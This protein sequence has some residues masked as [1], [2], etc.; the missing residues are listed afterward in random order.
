MRY[1]HQNREAIEHFS[2]GART[3]SAKHLNAI[4]DCVNE[5]SRPNP[6]IPQWEPTYE[7]E[8]GNT[9]PFKISL[10]IGDDA[11][12]VSVASGL[13]IG[14]GIS[15][16]GCAFGYH[17][18]N[19]EANTIS[20]PLYGYRDTFFFEA[21]TISL[22]YGKT[23]EKNIYIFVEAPTYYGRV[24][25]Y[26]SPG[27][28]TETEEG[29]DPP[30]VSKGYVHAE[31][32][33]EDD[34]EYIDWQAGAFPA[35][36]CIGWVNLKKGETVQLI[37]DNILF[38]VVPGACSPLVFHQV[39]GR[40]NSFRCKGGLLKMNLH[41]VDGFERLYPG[42]ELTFVNGTLSRWTETSIPAEPKEGRRF[43]SYITPIPPYELTV[44][45]NPIASEDSGINAGYT[46]QGY[47]VYI[48]V[49]MAYKKPDFAESEDGK[50]D[51]AAPEITWHSIAI[52]NETSKLESTWEFKDP[53]IAAPGE[54]NKHLLVTSFL[55]DSNEN[56]QPIESRYDVKFTE[57]MDT[58]DFPG[59]TS[60]IYKLEASCDAFESIIPVGIFCLPFPSDSVIDKP[61]DNPWKERYVY[62]P[63]EQ[64]VIN[65][66][67]PIHLY[68]DKYP[69][70]ESEL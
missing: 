11:V 40:K 42:G 45:D 28:E 18:N 2:A 8:T 61:S 64:G 56:G 59:L 30:P 34:P 1:R 46:A 10:S 67:P 24:M 51:F 58:I 47:L 33:K 16:R 7:Q 27:F 39:D 20:N 15:A 60:I 19:P 6:A 29:E 37:K 22:R 63:L 5:L 49:N 41:T 3:L 54:A 69:K 14:D 35:R 70:S 17:P 4:V 43:Y 50:L 44:G 25:G 21:Q 53:K 57:N 55:A 48:K 66:T 13:W 62:L 65:W 23:E 9:H 31:V 12:K 52:P 26:C 36:I 68:R 32:H 38:P